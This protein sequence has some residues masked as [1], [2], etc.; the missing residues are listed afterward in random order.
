MDS[1]DAI[2]CFHTPQSAIGHSPFSAIFVDAAMWKK[3]FL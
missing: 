1:H 2:F 3:Q